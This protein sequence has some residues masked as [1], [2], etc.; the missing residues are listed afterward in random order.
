MLR[1]LGFIG[2]WLGLALSAWAADQPGLIS[3]RVRNA[4]GAPQMGALVEILGSASQTLRLFTDENGFYSA[5]GLSPGTYTVMVSA[6]SFLSAWRENL[7]VR[8]GG[9]LKVDVTLHTLLDAV[10]LAPK[11]GVTQEDDWK[12]VLRSVSNRPIL[13]FVDTASSP[14][15]AK[16][17]DGK[18]EL[19]GSLSFIAGSAS[20][21]FGGASDMSTGFSV[22]RSI[23][24]SDTIALR[25]NVGYGSVSPASV[26]RATYDHKMGNGSD[27]QVALTIRNLPAPGILPSGGLQALALTTS[28][29]ITLGDFLELRVGSELQTVEFLGRVTAFRPFGS[30]DVHLS[31][32]TVVE[33][34]YATSEPDSR[35]DRGFESA[36]ADLSDSG[37]RVTMTGYSSTIE[38]AHHQELSLSHHVGKDSLQVAAYLDRISDPALTG[39]GELSTDGGDVLP[40]LYSGTFTF[41]GSDLKTGGM[42]IVAQRQLTSNLTGTFDYAYGGVLELA[43]SDIGLQDAQ[44]LMG[45][46][47]RHAVTGKLSGV[48]PKTKTHWIA[49]YRWVNGSALTPVDLFNV[50]AGEAEPYLNLFLRQPVPGTGFLPVHMEAL[51]DVRNLLAQ[52][53]VPMVAQDGHTVYLVQAARAVR[54]GLSFTF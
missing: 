32:D 15:P 35:I 16:T 13:R 17:Q 42:R 21:G 29:E 27:P 9:D 24:S 26:F 53:Y 20:E 8:A 38:R 23:F 54:G 18:H 19:K 52:G 37:P 31:P 1:K 3:G 41:Q 43:K 47:Y 11:R 49:S 12:W 5:R 2:L 44:E 48:V 25:G 10:E 7:G 28:D 39:V 22:E 46:R 36:P 4:A 34:R 51:I 14:S 40:D 6:P 30:V 33:Y 50:S 45:R